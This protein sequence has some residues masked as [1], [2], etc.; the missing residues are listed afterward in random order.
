MRR[1]LLSILTLLVS[2]PL[3][4]SI[5]GVVINTDGAPIAGA[6][7]S[8]FASETIEAR[9]VRLL[10]KTPERVALTAKQTDSKGNFTFDSPKEN[11]VVDLRVDAAGFAPETMRLL[12]DDDV[13]AV[14]LTQAP[15]KRGTITANGKP[16][17][18][19][20][21]IWLG[22]GT[23]DFVATT[24]AD[25]HYNA[26]DPSKWA[27]RLNIAHPDYAMFEE[28]TL[29]RDSQK[30][31]DFSLSAGVTITGRVVAE[32]GKTPMAKA[33]LLL[34]RWP[35]GTSADDGTFTIA[36]APKE[37]RQLEART[38]TLGAMRARSGEGAVALRLG[39]LAKISGTVRDAKTQFPLYGAEVRLAPAMLMMMMP[40]AAS[41]A[42]S[43]FADAK[44][45]YSIATIPGQYSLNAVHPSSVIPNANIHLTAGQSLNKPLYATAR[46]RVS[47]VV[48]DEDK[49]P[50]AAARVAARNANRDPMA[51][52]MVGRFQ[53]QDAMAYSAP[54]G[55]FALRNVMTET[56]M[57]IDAAKK[58]FPLGRTSSLR[59]NPGEK[60]T[61]VVITVPRGV[62]FS[63]KVTDNN[64][65]PLSGV[66][67]E[68]VEATAGPGMGMRRMVVNLMR[69]RDEEVVRTGS[70]GS[71]VLRLK[72]GTYD[73]VFKREGFAAKSLRSQTVNAST[74]PVD[75]RLDPGVEISG[76]VVRSGAG[77]EGVNVGAFSQ[78]ANANTVTASD[79]TFTL[80]DLTPGQMML[81]ATKPDAFIQQ[82]RPVT[83]PARDVVI[84]LPAGGRI[85]GRV[86][87]KSNKRPVPAFQAGISTARGGGG[88]V[89]MTPPMLKPF[90]TDDGSFTL[91]NVPAGP[92]QLVVSAPGYTMTN[93]PG[94]NVEEGKTLSDVEVLLDT[95]VKLTGRVTGPDGTP[96][97][98]VNVRL[99][100][101]AQ[102]QRVM[103]IGPTD[104]NV[105]TDPNGEYTLEALEEGEKTFVF[106]RQGYLGEQRTINLSGKEARLDVQL[107][108]GVRLTG[109][110]TTE[111]GVPVAEASVN[112]MSP[113]DPSFGRQARTDANGNFQMEGLAPGHYTLNASKAGMASGILRDFD[114]AAGAPARI[115][116]KSGGT[117]MGHVTGLTERELQQTV[118]MANGANGNASREVDS[119]GN[120][121]IE[122]A[123][124]GTVRVS[125][126]TGQGFGGGMKTSPV[127]SVEVDP[128]SSVQV[129]IEF[130]SGTVVR[131]RVTRNGQALANAIVMFAPRNA[132]TQT[133]ASGT[134]DSNG[135]YEVNGLD[136]GSY[137]VQVVDLDRTAPFTGTYNVHG[138]S[139]Y[140]IDIKASALRGRV[141]DSAT[142]QP[143]SGATVD[144]RSGTAGEAMLSSRVAPT[145]AA[146][147][148]VIDNVP[149]GSYQAKAEKVGYGHEVR[150]VVVGDTASGDVAFKLSPSSGVTLRVIDGRDNRLIGARVVRIID[151]GGREVDTGGFRFGSSPEPL[152]LTLASGSYRVTLG[153][154]GYAP[155]TVN[156]VS[157][158]EQ[159]VSM[160]PGG[161]L[162]MRGKKS[163]SQRV[164]LMDTGGSTYPRGQNGIFMIDPSPLSTTLNNVAVGTYTVQV[165]DSAD[166]VVNSVP[167]TVVEGRETVVEI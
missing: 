66:G 20:V 17:A 69:D 141:T 166:R 113:S 27:N 121:R 116:M 147:N 140:D 96:L 115:V 56:D 93:M 119:S 78:D 150:N 167:V 138:S 94:L 3:S 155:R 74:A 154:M 91:E 36:H 25:G 43:V 85:T 134:T 67:V 4:A 72:E 133:Q 42:G 18:G 30:R 73:V 37:W 125:A 126:R 118:V 103:R 11:P 135:A 99:D 41:P 139:N 86:V 111:A 95:G 146:G 159:T 39:K 89:I 87:E 122:G 157:P 124:T 47:G 130:K 52:M 83:A 160:T 33:T 77:V 142:G 120:Y 63:G 48:V 92:T 12:A 165:L 158:S 151:S 31:V 2:L 76:R 8:L 102:G 44:G 100:Q 127:K 101:M 84:E 10:S 88:M 62:A 136:D 57:Q 107:S 161:T 80:T 65:K 28:L 51:M 64:G 49:R 53:Q 156:V 55:R 26:P 128:G 16:V 24:D 29:Q 13:G 144:I 81:S 50:I 15:M 104:S 9:R 75:V 19:A 40:G 46:A 153:A 112:A 145:D 6:K 97:S 82:I 14:A 148:F 61:G 60:K 23:A 58:G 109:T 129:D 35:V 98:G 117:I 7:V 114:V 70:D 45:A 131:G 34:D 90:T 110:V 123:P 137:N 71:F 132:Q 32:D 108:S 162:V 149:R 1:S 59:L 79:G 54:D 164:R 152:K 22:G 5:S 163:A 38:A 106:S 105:A 68:A 143:I 21:V